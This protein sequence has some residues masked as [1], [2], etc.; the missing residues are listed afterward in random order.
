MSFGK[1][2]GGKKGGG[3]MVRGEARGRKAPPTPRLMMERYAGEPGIALTEDALAPLDQ[4][5]SDL[6]RKLSLANQKRMAVFFRARLLSA[7]QERRAETGDPE[8]ALSAEDI[9]VAIKVTG[10]AMMN[11]SGRSA[12]SWSSKRVL[13]DACPFC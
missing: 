5:N 12:L 9:I 8:A 13:R 7:S 6:L 4:L 3:G 11:L 2:G 1:R 10:Q